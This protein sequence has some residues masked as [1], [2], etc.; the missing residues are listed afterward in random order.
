MHML[1]ADRKLTNKEIRLI[2]DILDCDKTICDSEIFTYYFY[3][4]KDSTQ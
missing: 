4:K 3:V 2:M 1:I